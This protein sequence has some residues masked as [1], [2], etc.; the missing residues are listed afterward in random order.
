MV[1]LLLEVQELFQR[2]SIPRID[3]VEE[4]RALKSPNFIDGE[5]EYT[6]SA[7]AKTQQALSP[8]FPR[9]SSEAFD[10]LARNIYWS[11]R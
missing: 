11:K 9:C 10:L 1:V 6:S 7:K 5:S 8:S 3:F 2:F 4:T